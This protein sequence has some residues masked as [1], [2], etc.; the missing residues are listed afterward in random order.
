MKNKFILFS[1]TFLLTM[2]TPCSSYATELTQPEKP[3]IHNEQAVNQYN[4]EVG[5]YNKQIDKIYQ[6]ELK[7]YNDAVDYN[8]QEK[9]RVDQ[10]N[11]EQEEIVNQ[12]N[13]E[14]NAKVEQNQKDLEKQE[15]INTRI[16]HDTNNGLENSTSN[17]NSAPTTFEGE[18]KIPKTTIVEKSDAPTDIFYKLV[19]IHIFTN[20]KDYFDDTEI[21]PDKFSLAESLLAQAVLIEWET[22]L[23]NEN[24]I[25]HAHSQDVMWN[26]QYGMFRRCLKG[27]TNG[28]WWGNSGICLSDAINCD[29]KYINGSWEY[30][31]SYNEGTDW[32][33]DMD[34]VIIYWIYSFI[35]YGAEP[36][37]VTK[38]IPDYWTVK[39][40]T[41]NYLTAIVPIKGK[42]LSLLKYI[43]LNNNNNN[44]N[45]DIVTS[46]EDNLFTLVPTKSNT[47]TTVGTKT[48]K[49]TKIPLYN[50]ARKNSYWALLNLII[51]I[52]SIIL[53]ILFIILYFYKRKTKEEEE[54]NQTI[55]K[56]KS[57]I[58]RLFSMLCSIVAVIVFILTE[59]MSL[60]MQWTDKYT[61]LMA[62]ILILQIIG[63]I[64]IRKKK[65]QDNNN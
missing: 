10:V 21:F 57:F 58:K 28:V 62:I 9:Q 8:N 49:N 46:T 60:P 2:S 59:D 7:E 23:A 24:D 14:E 41:P 37:E 48:I 36:E 18:T 31:H 29:S 30:Y 42:Y 33:R 11:A 4:Q 38:Y 39:Y 32:N 65:Q 35:R 45:N 44:S 50:S 26:G 51:T 15:K 5:Q 1:L 63:L 55:I 17:P 61:I 6:E 19:N 20:G 13:T 34:N 64:I 12:H 16:K 53:T 52:I 25:V 27:Y 47:S 54:N 3:D 56:K 43:P 40:E 22:V